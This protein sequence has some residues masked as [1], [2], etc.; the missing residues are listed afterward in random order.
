M[1]KYFYL[2]LTIAM[3]GI[4][5]GDDTPDVQ[6]YKDGVF[7]VNQGAFQSGT[8]TLTFLA[9]GADTIST[10]VYSAANAGAVLGNIAQSMTEFDGKKYIAVNNAEKI[11]IAN[12]KTL[13]NVGEIAGIGQS[14]YFVSNDDNLYVSSWGTGFSGGV[15]EINTSTNTLSEPIV[16]GNGAEGM[17]IVDNLLYVARSGGFGRDSVVSV[18]DIDNNTLVNTIVVGDK[19]EILVASNNG[20]VFVICNG[21][22]DWMEPAN[23]TNGRLVK[24]SGTTIESSIELANGASKLA[25]DNDNDEIYYIESGK[26]IR[27]SIDLTNSETTDIASVF[28]SGLGFDQDENLLYVADSK[29]FASNGEITV[30]KRSGEK[31]N[32]FE[33]GII[34]SFFHFD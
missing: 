33:A 29:D 25:I 2:L 8:G 23:N 17:V 4:S 27:R 28:A 26:V 14:R 20:D 6:E 32:T 31:V 22:F 30:Y 10:D 18:I 1:K 3:L 19:P 21:Y 11:V 16:E 13:V 15:Y 24:I 5:C 7:V 12:D 9:N 34:P